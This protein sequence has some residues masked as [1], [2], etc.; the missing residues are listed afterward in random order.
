[1]INSVVK[2]KNNRIRAVQLVF[3]M[4]REILN[5]KNEY[6]VKI[7]GS[8][9]NIESLDVRRHLVLYGMSEFIISLVTWE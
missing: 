1:M 5:N 3:S 8:Q 7:H 4:F 6:W 2:I 9:Y